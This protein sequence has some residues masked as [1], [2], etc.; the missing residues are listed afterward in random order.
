MRFD[1]GPK[2][3]DSRLSRGLEAAASMDHAPNG[4]V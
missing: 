4:E 2:R 3:F 1:Q